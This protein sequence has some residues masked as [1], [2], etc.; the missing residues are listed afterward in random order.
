MDELTSI[1]I[2]LLCIAPWLVTEINLQ[3]AF[4]GFSRRVFA[5]PTNGAY[6][7]CIVAVATIGASLIGVGAQNFLVYLGLLQE[8]IFDTFEIILIGASTIA[9][10]YQVLWWLS[11]HYFKSGVKRHGGIAPSC[12]RCA[13]NLTGLDLRRGSIRCPECGH[14]EPL[15]S[16]IARLV[17]ERHL[18]DQMK[19]GSE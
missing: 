2:G 9:V 16:V 18:H 1:A 12:A 17:L 19:K 13:Y 3:L 6:R 14:I 11:H 8:P 10:L 7:I 5:S 15:R 4:F